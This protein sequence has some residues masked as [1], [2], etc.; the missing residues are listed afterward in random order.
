M[1]ANCEHLDKIKALEIENGSYIAKFSNQNQLIASLETEVE[2]LSNE[3]KLL[4][5]TSKNFEQQ[6]IVL[7]KS[8][9][10]ISQSKSF[11]STTS[12]NIPSMPFNSPTSLVSSSLILKNFTDSSDASQEIPDPSLHPKESTESLLPAKTLNLLYSASSPEIGRKYEPDE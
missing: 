5:K 2:K 8:P 1:E 12:S 3:K 9:S 11:S 6:S 7:E 4:D 10:S